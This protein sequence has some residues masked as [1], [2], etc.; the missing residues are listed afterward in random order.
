MK[1]IKILKGHFWTHGIEDPIKYLAGKLE[2]K[3][4]TIRIFC[5]QAINGVGSGKGQLNPKTA[6]WI[7]EQSFKVME[8]GEIRNPVQLFL[9]SKGEKIDG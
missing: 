6:A 2:F 8:Q 4:E 7:I 5:R 9:E 1:F 3:P